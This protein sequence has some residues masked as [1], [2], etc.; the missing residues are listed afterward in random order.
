MSV[1]SQNDVTG[2]KQRKSGLS[3]ASQFEL[4]VYRTSGRG[5]DQFTRMPLLQANA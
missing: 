1:Y 2:T 5:T 4:T 3:Q